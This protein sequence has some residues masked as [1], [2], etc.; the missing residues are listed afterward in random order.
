[1]GSKGQ[2]SQN[3]HLHM[4]EAYTNLLRAWPDPTLKNDLS[5]LVDVM[6]TKVLDAS[7]HHL[8]LFFN[9]DWAPSSH[10]FS[11]GHDIEFSWLITEATDVLA[12][13]QLSTRAKA[14]AESIAAVTLREGVEPNGGV[15]AEGGA[16]GVTN[17]FKE[18]WTQAEA[19]VGF[20]N[21]FQLSGSPVYLDASLKTWDYI[22]QNLVDRQNGEW[23]IGVSADGTVPSPVKI[24]FWKCPYHNGRACLELLH[25][26]RAI[27][28][29]R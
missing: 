25:R 27:E 24:S 11:Y 15:V 19:A 29:T 12:D 23:F 26:L 28:Q 8:H 6:L 22:D 4:L 20:L 10:E 5:E 9:E 2:K 13:A 17:R 14:A 1:M 18:W 21:A 16:H 7:T 3:T